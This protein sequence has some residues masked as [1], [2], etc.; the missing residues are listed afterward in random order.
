MIKSFGHL[1]PSAFVLF[2]LISSIVPS[3]ITGFTIPT[4][5]LR[6]P[7]RSL[8]MTK[9]KAR[10]SARRENVRT[11]IQSHVQSPSPMRMAASVW[12]DN[13]GVELVAELLRMLVLE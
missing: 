9:T 3:I 10:T 13:E 1:V 4:S 12:V 2:F 7:R 5:Q 6:Y 11:M 8:P